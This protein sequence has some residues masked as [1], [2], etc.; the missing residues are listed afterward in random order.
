MVAEVLPF[1]ISHVL[2][3][4][5]SRALPNR[6]LNKD[7]IATIS[8]ALAEKLQELKTMGSADSEELKSIL[9]LVVD[10]TFENLS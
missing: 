10:E 6:Q 4:F 1:V 2:S 9:K 8:Q 7:F 3:E 5:G